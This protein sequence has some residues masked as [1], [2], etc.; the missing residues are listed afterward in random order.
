MTAAVEPVLSTPAAVAA[1]V[2]SRA[3]NPTGVQLAASFPPRPA[4]AS[5]PATEANRSAVLDRVLAAPF[6][7]DNPNSQQTRR[8]GVLAVMNWLRTHPATVG[9]GGG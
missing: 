8:L 3:A 6:A 2:A 9:S 4:G 1:P 7:L 5:W